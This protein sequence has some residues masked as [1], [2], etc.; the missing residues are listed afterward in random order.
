MRRVKQHILL[1]SPR[2][3][4]LS[5]ERDMALTSRLQRGEYLAGTADELVQLERERRPALGRAHIMGSH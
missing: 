3:E 1:L 2:R 4:T 5:I